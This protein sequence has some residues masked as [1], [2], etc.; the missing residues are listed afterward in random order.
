MAD[1]P[2]T[3]ELE[4]AV[5]RFGEA[6]ASGDLKT[7]EPLL[8]PTYTHTD[9]FGAFHDKAAWLDYVGGRAGRSTQISF[10]DV[11]IRRL[12]DFAIVTGTNDLTGPGIRNKGDQAP[13]SM[14]FTQVW[15]LKNGQWLRE[16]F[17]ATP[18]KAD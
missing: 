8:S 16:A 10:R 5:R 18:I 15:I 14:R 12:G 17:Q 2:N 3:A 4:V 1:D 13:Q 9:G 7:L 11:E 6:W